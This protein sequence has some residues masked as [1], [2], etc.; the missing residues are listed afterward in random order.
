MRSDLMGIVWKER[1][2]VIMLTH[3][4]AEGNFCDEYG[5]ILKPATIQDNDT[6]CYVDRNDHMT[7]S[8]SISIHTW[9]WM[10]NCF[11]ISWSF[12]F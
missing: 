7:N 9:K 10:K 3:P 11:F 12:Q 2:D 4:T 8:Y 5:N 1:W 6:W